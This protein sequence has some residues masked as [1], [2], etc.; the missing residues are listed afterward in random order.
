MVWT[1]DVVIILMAAYA[2]VSAII[3]ID[4]WNTMSRPKLFANDYSGHN[5]W[6]IGSTNVDQQV[7][8][9]ITF[10]IIVFGLTI[11][12]KVM[13]RH[14]GSSF[15]ELHKQATYAKLEQITSWA[16]WL[17]LI[18]SSCAWWVMP[19]VT[20]YVFQ[21]DHPRTELVEK[22]T[23]TAKNFT[24]KSGDKFVVK[25]ETYYVPKENIERV[26]YLNKS[27]AKIRLTYLTP[28]KDLPDY[29]KRAFYPSILRFS[30]LSDYSTAT[31]VEN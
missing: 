4:K 15:G 8:A 22:H 27:D 2:V 17:F 9:L 21:N 23:V 5:V 10:V 12:A 16:I 26:Y 28:K 7:L 19:K 18:I 31:I 14:A 25:G 1:A 24:Q 13:L 3:S 6:L 20:S 29:Y 30:T 11:L